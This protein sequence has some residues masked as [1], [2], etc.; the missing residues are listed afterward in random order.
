MAGA[1]NGTALA[2]QVRESLAP[3][4][5]ALRRGQAGGR[6][7]Q[8][9]DGLW[10]WCPGLDVARLKWASSRRDGRRWRIVLSISM[11]EPLWYIR[12]TLE[13]ALTRTAETTLILLHLSAGSNYELTSSSIKDLE[14]L[15]AQQRVEVS[16][17]RH[18]VTAYTGTVLLSQLS[19]LQWARC[20]GLLHEVTHVVFQAS[21]MW[22]WRSGMEI[23][24]YEHQSST[25]LISSVGECAAYAQSKQ[26][27]GT[28]QICF[29]ISSRKTSLAHVVEKVSTID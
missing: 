17:F 13:N 21:N 23:A 2:A 29:P 5:R 18:H 15:W 11:F 6:T 25:P 1:V 3:M 16:C 9:S 20:R 19:N 10:S 12:E 7:R 26:N 27:D 8:Q 28:H 14:W 4:M 24:V 22:W